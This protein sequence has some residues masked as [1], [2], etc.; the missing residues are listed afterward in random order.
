MNQYGQNRVIPKYVRVIVHILFMLYGATIIFSLYYIIINS[1]KTDAEYAKSAL[2][3]LG[4]HF[5]NFSQ[6]WHQIGL[7]RAVF[8]SLVYTLGGLA[9]AFVCAC[10]ASFSFGFLRFKGKK[11]LFQLVMLTMYMAPMSIILALYL[12]Y[13][14]LKLTNNVIGIIIIYAAICLSF[15]IFIITNAFRGVPYEVY[16]SARIDGAHNLRILT[17]I[18]L[19][20]TRP[21]WITF[22]IVYF[23]TLWSDLLFGLI[24][25]QKPE[26][27]TAMVVVSGLK[28]GR[29][30]SS[31]VALFTGLTILTIPTLI[32][33]TVAQKYFTLGISDGSVKG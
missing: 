32:L 28:G 11:I 2:L 15:G 24:F 16:E 5:E 23:N 22:L 26:Y 10:L 14:N 7:G 4:L 33:Y 27:A 19:P 20:M 18:I 25:M 13:I 9:V 30:A 17:Q 29:Y 31:F 12:Q 21:S 1:L 3:P 8:N 6:V